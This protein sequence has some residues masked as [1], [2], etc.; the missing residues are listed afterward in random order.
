MNVFKIRINSTFAVLVDQISFTVG[1]HGYSAGAIIESRIA[2][3]NGGHGDAKIRRALDVGTS[4]RR[5]GVEPGRIHAIETWTA[6][7]LIDFE[8]RLI[9]SIGR[10]RS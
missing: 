7:C 9:V 5:R 8:V 4:R 10:S 1:R 2:G 6:G 3:R